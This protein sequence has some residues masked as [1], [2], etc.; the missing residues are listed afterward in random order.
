MLGRSGKDVVPESKSGVINILAWLRLFRFHAL[1]IV[2]IATLAVSLLLDIVI[3]EAVILALISVLG[4]AAGNTHNDVYDKDA[5]ARTPHKAWRP[6]PSGII[7]PHSAMNMSYFLY[8]LVVMLG[9]TLSIQVGVLTVAYVGLLHLYNERARQ[10][11]GLFGHIVASV[12]T[13]SCVVL[14]MAHAW[15]WSLYPLALGLFMLETAREIIVSI[16][17]R[18]EGVKTLVGEVG[19]DSCRHIAQVWIIGWFLVFPLAVSLTPK[20]GA[21][22]HTAGIVWGVGLFV[23]LYFA[24]VSDT[25]KQWKMFQI[26]TKAPMVIF[27]L[28]LLL[29][30]W[31]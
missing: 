16:P 15:R 12:L 27:V 17:D 19:T 4:L 2:F 26:L 31:F 25:S 10:S 21:L 11:W 14:P 20:L 8:G 3:R 13:T 29:E 6:I 24:N 7:H 30:V 1:S 18:D 9:L 22:Y 28:A 23:S 5:D